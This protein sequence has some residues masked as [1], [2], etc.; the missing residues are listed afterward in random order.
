MNHN[1]KNAI[2]FKGFVLLTFSHSTCSLC[3]CV[4]WGGR[5]AFNCCFVARSMLPPPPVPPRCRGPGCSRH[6]R[7]GRM[8]PGQGSR[9]HCSPSAQPH[10]QASLNFPVAQQHDY[11]P[12]CVVFL[13]V[14]KGSAL[15]RGLLRHAFNLVISTEFTC[16][17]I[18]WIIGFERP[19]YL[20]DLIL[21]GTQR[22]GVQSHVSVNQ[23]TVWDKNKN[24]LIISV[25]PLPQQW[26]LRPGR[27]PRCAHRL[28]SCLSS[29]SHATSVKRIKETDVRLELQKYHLHDRQIWIPFTEI[30]QVFINFTY[31]KWEK[32]YA[33]WE[34]TSF[35]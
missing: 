10:T 1:M 9:S 22:F 34:I 21:Q 11:L 8:A 30:D 4:L 25:T 23:F 31:S 12:F 35:E 28:P 32:V 16:W 26:W 2:I 18:Y 33:K 19:V 15:T 27:K 7:P 14:W 6:K 3:L 17:L 29:P 13:L 24:Q 5:K 20:T